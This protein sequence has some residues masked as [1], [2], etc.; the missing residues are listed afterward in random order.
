MSMSSG[1]ASIASALARLAL[2]M[3][4][5]FFMFFALSPALELLPGGM[6]AVV[7]VLLAALFLV[8]AIT[9]LRRRK[10]R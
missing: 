3:A 5:L 8:W 6:D 1:L 10:R 2:L 4:S 9:G 7:A